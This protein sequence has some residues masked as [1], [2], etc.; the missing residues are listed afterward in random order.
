MNE[1]YLYTIRH[2][3]GVIAYILAVSF[4]AAIAALDW[5]ADRCNIIF[6]N[7]VDAYVINREFA[8]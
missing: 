7:P 8:G 3:S 5:D 6:T 4:E 1:M 2:N